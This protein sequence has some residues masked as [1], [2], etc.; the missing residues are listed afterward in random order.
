MK[1]T[2]DRQIKAAMGLLLVLAALVFRTM[3]PLW[4]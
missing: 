3:E 4:A 2:F 1:M